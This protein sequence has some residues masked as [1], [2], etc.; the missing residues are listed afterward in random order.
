[1]GETVYTL[2]YLP[3]GGFVKLEGEDGTDTDDPRSFSSQG[4]PLKLLIL[5]AGVLM[6]IALAF[7]IFT[8]IALGGDP[9]IA[10]SATTIQAGSPAA[11]AGLQPGVVIVSLNGKAYGAFA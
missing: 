5:I 6:N 8:G 11:G 4:L 3:I 1:R 10:V 9:T 2:N 7:A